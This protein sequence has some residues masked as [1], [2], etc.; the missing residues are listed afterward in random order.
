[1]FNPPELVKEY[2]KTLFADDGELPSPCFK[3][4]QQSELEE[5]E[6]GSSVDNRERHFDRD[7]DD[8]DREVSYIKFEVVHDD[9]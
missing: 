9:S 6:E 7:I 5:E 3:N 2:N 1:M 4:G 8:E